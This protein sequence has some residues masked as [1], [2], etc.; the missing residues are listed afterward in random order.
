MYPVPCTR[1]GSALDGSARGSSARLDDVGVP[2]APFWGSKRAAPLPAPCTLHPVSAPLPV[3]CT[4]RLAPAPLLDSG[5]DDSAP[6]GTGTGAGAGAA[7][8]AGSAAHAALHPAPCTLYLEAASHAALSMGIL[9]AVS[10]A[11]AG[12]MSEEPGSPVDTLYPAPC[13]TS[14][15]P[16]ASPMPCTLPAAAP[17]AST[18]LP[19]PCIAAEPS[20]RSMPCTL[21]AAA[22]SASTML[23]VPCIAAEPS[24]SKMLERTARPVGVCTVASL[25]EGPAATLS[26]A[27]ALPALPALP[28]TPAPCAA[29]S[30]L[31]APSAAA[32]SEVRRC[33]GAAEAASAA[34]EEGAASCR[35]YPVSCTLHSE[36][37][38]AAAAPDD[39]CVPRVRHTYHG[40]TGPTPIPVAEAEA[41][42][43]W[44]L[45]PLLAPC[46]L[47][48]AKAA[49]RSLAPVTPHLGE[50]FASFDSSFACFD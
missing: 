11:G 44:S 15:E 17:S 50:P 34:E 18:M 23:P 5:L 30:A 13:T 48:E 25:T 47:E 22:P 20:A 31:P 14:E 12:T 3:P 46:T 7:S 19:V 27:A 45:A 1:G 21:P 39:G 6:V 8:C 32:S 38:A 2:S 42:G 28:C 37:A 40:T 4:P 16:S 24:A 36:A 9:A 29:S 33:G 35:L 10:A 49:G 41:A 43:R 26:P